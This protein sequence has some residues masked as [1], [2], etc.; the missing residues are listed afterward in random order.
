MN[1]KKEKM[2]KY[3]REIRELKNTR[4]YLKNTLKGFKNRLDKAERLVIWKTGQWNSPKQGS[5]KQ[6]PEF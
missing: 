4:T 3:T 1:L 5:N 2:Q 6:T